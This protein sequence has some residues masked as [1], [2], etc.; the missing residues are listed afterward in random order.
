MRR[1]AGWW[2]YRRRL[3]ALAGEHLDNGCAVSPALYEQLRGQARAHRYERRVRA[4][5][6]IAESVPRETEKGV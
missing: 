3:A 1:L 6:R 2:R 4:G 5:L